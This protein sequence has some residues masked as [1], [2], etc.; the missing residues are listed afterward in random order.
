MDYKKLNDNE[1]V[2]MV[3]E[4]D[5]DYTNLLV[6]KYSPVIYRL[7]NEYYRRFSECGY[8]FEDFH[9]EA[10]N[11]F[12]K[13]IHTY[14][15]EHSALL[16]TYVNV[17]IK[18]ALSSFGRIAYRNRNKELDNVD[19]CDLEY[20]VEDKRENPD[21]RESYKELEK[22]VKGVIFSLS[23]E[24]GAILELKINGFTYKEISR[25]LDIPMSSV[26]FRSRRARNLL[27][28]KVRAFYC[29]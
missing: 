24:A 11:A 21:Y 16:Y 22:I 8:E 26:E 20:C 27:R 17:C 28:N 10:L 23:L 13:A 3:Q 14:N 7:S 25:L 12:Y 5:E 19:I 2:Y 18:R 1:L 6:K 9:Q 15:D 4:N 29:K